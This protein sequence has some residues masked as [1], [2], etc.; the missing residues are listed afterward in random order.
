MAVPF[1]I[2]TSNVRG[3]QFLHFLACVCVCVCAQAQLLSCVHSCI[4]WTVAHQA[5]LSMGF[6]RQE[7]WSGLPFPSPGDLPDPRI[8]LALDWQVDSLPLSHLR[9]PIPYQYLTLFFYSHPTRCKVLSHCG[10]DSPF[11]NAWHYQ[12]GGHEFE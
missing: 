7:Y 8:K 1:Y 9:S 12:L 6:P 3:F 4:P 2:I 11:P 10:F 5:P